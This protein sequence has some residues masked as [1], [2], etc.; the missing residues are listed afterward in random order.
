MAVIRGA[1]LEQG[2]ASRMKWQKGVQD[3]FFRG[4]SHGNATGRFNKLHDAIDQK[5]CIIQLKQIKKK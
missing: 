5:P 4:L 1:L 3:L 2:A